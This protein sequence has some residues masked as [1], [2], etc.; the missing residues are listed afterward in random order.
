MLLFVKR[1]L[2]KYDIP[3]VETLHAGRVRWK[4]DARPVFDLN[5]FKEINKS[6]Q[7][8]SMYDCN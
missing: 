6:Q 4:I 7:I 2:S 3:Q 5:C 8:C 1:Y